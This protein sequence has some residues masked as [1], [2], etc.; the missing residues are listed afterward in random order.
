MQFIKQLDPSTLLYI[1]V[2]LNSAWV[3]VLGSK[4]MHSLLGTPSKFISRGRLLAGRPGGR[5]QAFFWHGTVHWLDPPTG[6][7]WKPHHLELLLLSGGYLAR[8]GL[9]HLLSR[10]EA[11]RGDGKCV[12]TNAGFLWGD[13]YTHHEGRDSICMCYIN[14]AQEWVHCSTRGRHAG[15]LPSHID[16]WNSSS[17]WRR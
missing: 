5:S 14:T 11:G 2:M 13:E 8:R 1:P 4:A 17:H 12:H 15:S 10:L 6:M 16:I 7:Q 3:P 9:P